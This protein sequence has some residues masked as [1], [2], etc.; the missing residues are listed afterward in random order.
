MGVQPEVKVFT[1]LIADFIN[2]TFPPDLTRTYLVGEKVGSGSTAEVRLCYRFPKMSRYAVKLVNHSKEEWGSKYSKPTDL[3]TEVEVLEKVDHPCAVKV[4]DVV[5]TDTLLAIVME[6]ASGG[7]LFDQVIKDERAK[8]LKEEIAKFQFVQ[9]V[10]CVRHLHSLNIC[11]RDLK[12]ENLLLARPGAR[13]LIKLT[14]FG[15]A[16]VWGLG[17]IL[18]TYAAKSDCWSL[19]VILFLLL[20]GRHPFPCNLP[21]E[22]RDKRLREGARMAMQGVRWSHISE[23]ARYLVEAL[24]EVDPERRLSC[25]EA[26]AHPWQL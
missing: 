16:K 26:L 7:E 17:G 18:E 5:E 22:E 21:D 20:S 23:E 13:S 2:K 10:D 8:S 3:K 4:V 25:E 1:V 24:L 12:L 11:H 15:L 6:Y 14:D 9:V 19:G